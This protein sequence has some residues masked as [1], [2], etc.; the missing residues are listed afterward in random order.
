MVVGAVLVNLGVVENIVALHG[1]L[2]CDPL[3]DFLVEDALLRKLVVHVSLRWNFVSS[4]L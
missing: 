4:G 3:V 2:A 1:P